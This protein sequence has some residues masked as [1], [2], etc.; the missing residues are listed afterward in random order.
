ML[1]EIIKRVHE[2]HTRNPTIAPAALSNRLW[3]CRW[4]ASMPCGLRRRKRKS[5]AKK[6]DCWGMCPKELLAR[7]HGQPATEEIP[8]LKVKFLGMGDYR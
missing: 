2:E 1:T 7:G 4:R 5:G 8:N 6:K 3:C